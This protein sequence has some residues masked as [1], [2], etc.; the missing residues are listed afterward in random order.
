MSSQ[1]TTEPPASA[2]VILHTTAGPIPLS[3]FATQTPLTCRN[4]L[5]HSLDGYYDG[6][7]WHR[8]AAG[9][10]IQTGDP[11]GT[12]EGGENIYEDKEFERYDKVWAKLLGRE[13]REK[14]V[15]KD[16]VHSRLKFNRRGL[17]GMAKQSD[18][19][20]GSQF[21]ITLGDARAQLDGKCTMFGRV[22][23]EGI[24]NMVKI[25]EGEVD[26]KNERPIYP[27]R[28]L[29]V[30]ITQMP[31]GEAWEGMKKRERVERR[32]E[33]VTKKK[34]MGKKKAKK[35][36]LSFGEEEKDEELDV[37]VK[38]KKAKFNTALID[39]STVVEE[40]P[41]TNGYVARKADEPPPPKRRKPSVSPS[42]REKLLAS[43]TAQSP[44]TY[45]STEASH[46][47][48]PSFHEPTTQLPLRDEEM[49]SRSVSPD[50]PIRVMGPSKSSLE[51]EITALKASMRRDTAPV[52]SK[53]K[54]LSALEAMIPATSTRGRK[55]PRPGETN[56][57]EDKNALAML[58]AF[59]ARL[60]SVKELDMP[61]AASSTI[62]AESKR[63]NGL[64]I[65]SS[66]SVK[67]EAADDEEEAQLCDLHFIANCQSCSR[68][69]ENLD[70]K[71]DDD[72]DDPGWMSHKLAFG[73]DQ[74]GKDLNF[75]KRNEALE[76]LV[77]IDPREKAGQILAAEREKRRQR[78][79]ARRRG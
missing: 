79:E 75:K 34:V 12:G 21:Y 16:E 62:A 72:A 70:E 71:E 33:E 10:V 63:M 47:R 6:V 45:R 17:L 32:V 39:T 57:R 60:D 77:V 78:K 9:F 74:L 14:I 40:T 50:S 73:K 52:V 49:P 24:Y 2:S 27:E 20:Y 36:L 54:K 37:L 58:N 1:Y 22:E 68:W 15:F 3:L 42:R 26:E 29:R 61:D 5:Q 69:D 51:A 8:I 67:P 35:T 43:M 64:K 44:P 66:D 4:F 55:R 31:V 18:G 28:V 11:S 19:G 41:K 65:G 38:P 59:K 46:K 76:E 25:A 48:K 7:L 13:E 23:G 56:Q 30:E 53:N